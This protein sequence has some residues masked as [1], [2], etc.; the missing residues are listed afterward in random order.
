MPRTDVLDSFFAKNQ[1]QNEEN[2]KH[3]ERKEK[4]R[5]KIKQQNDRLTD[6]QRKYQE[7]IKRAKHEQIINNLNN[8]TS[9][10][11]PE[12]YKVKKPEKQNSQHAASQN[13]KSNGF[14]IDT[15]RRALSR[16]E[17]EK[18]KRR[19]SPNQ[20]DSP[21]VSGKKLDQKRKSEHIEDV[22]KKKKKKKSS[23]EAP[24]NKSSDSEDYERIKIKKKEKKHKQD[25]HKSDRSSSKVHVSSS[26]K[27]SGTNKSFD[28]NAI[29]AKAKKN[30][31]IDPEEKIRELKKQ[32][33]E[34]KRVEFE[35]KELA[36]KRKQ[37]QENSEQRNRK[38]IDKAREAKRQAEISQ[39]NNEKR[40]KILEKMEK[41]AEEKEANLLKKAAK[42]NPYAKQEK[43]KIS[44]SKP[45]LD[46]NMD[47]SMEAIKKA[48]EKYKVKSKSSENKTKQT[49]KPSPSNAVDPKEQEIAKL[50]AQIALYKKQDQQQY[51]KQPKKSKK[52]SKSSSSYSTPPISTDMDNYY[53]PT[54]HRPSLH[55]P[56]SR[57]HMNPR[58]PDRFSDDEDYYDDSE[59]DSSM[60]DFI[61][62]DDEEVSR[63]ARKMMKKVTGY[64]P[65][66]F[67]HIDVSDRA[68]AGMQTKQWD[69]DKEEKRSARIAKKEDAEELAKEKALEALE[70][71]KKAKKAK[72][73]K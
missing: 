60:D 38:S 5:K 2:L 4:A 28:M 45:V 53:R 67:K 27:A 33:D 17:M 9:L 55:N 3:L 73:R 25:K 34:Q 47:F 10:T 51:H 68:L 64:D 63:K 58:M 70:K 11:I 61:A 23:I 37:A 50:K 21:K 35:E 13:I 30:E 48:A 20:S 71:K 12:K 41:E 57:Y 19:M 29:F 26:K 69:L 1:K 44:K 18:Y 62:S 31:G 42:L 52:S 40:K 65:K 6:H 54:L 7:S 56:S 46:N 49:I 15:K 22:K 32:Q 16:E 66:K 24:V 43:A 72:K 39:K 8:K 36:R 59:E 14:D